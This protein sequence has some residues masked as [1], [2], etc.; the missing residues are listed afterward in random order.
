M[1]RLQERRGLNENIVIIILAIALHFILEE[2][3]GPCPTYC[4][5]DHKHNINTEELMNE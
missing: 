4:A 2:R 3:P 5:V 1:E